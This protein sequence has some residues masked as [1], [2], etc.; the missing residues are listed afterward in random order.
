VKEGVSGSGCGR[1]YWSLLALI[2]TYRSLVILSSISENG[3]QS[4]GFI[5]VKQLVASPLEY[6]PIEWL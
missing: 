3:G 6:S 2:G 4:T 5:K 1:A